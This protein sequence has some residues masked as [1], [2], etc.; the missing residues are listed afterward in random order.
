MYLRG[1]Y[2]S[3]EPS[4]SVFC[5]LRC[6]SCGFIQGASYP[7]RASTCKRCSKKLDIIKNPPIEKFR[8]LKEMQANL[9]S[10]K[11]NDE[12]TPLNKMLEKDLERRPNNKNTLRETIIEKIG[13]HGIEKKVLIRELSI[14]DYEVNDI[15]L[16]I[17]ELK[18]S[19]I[20]YSPSY[21]F[22]R[23]VK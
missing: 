13:I 2:L 7:I 18:L 21:E 5:I 22:Y 14:H 17:I 12:N 20:I 11:W 15:D 3:Y 10:I 23:I 6:R 4:G 1:V 8:S 16:T 9:I 19:G